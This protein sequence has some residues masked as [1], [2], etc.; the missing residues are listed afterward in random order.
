MLD[1]RIF[2]RVPVRLRPCNSISYRGV[3]CQDCITV[4]NN[5]RL[6]HA[7]FPHLSCQAIGRF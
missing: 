6:I 7:K 5:A 3:R 4:H 1:T 2:S